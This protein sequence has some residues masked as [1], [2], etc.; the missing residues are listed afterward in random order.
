MADLYAQ[1]VGKFAEWPETNYVCSWEGEGMEPI[2]S[3]HLAGPRG[4][5]LLRL[6]PQGGF[7]AWAADEQQTP[8]FWAEPSGDSGTWLPDGAGR[9]TGP[10]DAAAVLGALPL[11][12]P[13]SVYAWG[14]GKPTVLA[15]WHH[16]GIRADAPLQLVRFTHEGNVWE[17]HLTADLATWWNDRGTGLVQCLDEEVASGRHLLTVEPDGHGY[18]KFVLDGASYLVDVPLPGG[19]LNHVPG[20]GDPARMRAACAS[21]AEARTAAAGL[22]PPPF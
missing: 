10:V 17:N 15:Y 8:G 19:P 7:C 11:P 20:A 2:V 1:L 18:V 13:G 4:H 9:I 16:T 6:Y 22:L 3:K 14:T 12:Q 21:Y 5:I